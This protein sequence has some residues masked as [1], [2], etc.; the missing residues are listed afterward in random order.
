[1][2]WHIETSGAR[3][4]NRVTID[5]VSDDDPRSEIRHV[6]IRVTPRIGELPTMPFFPEGMVYTD[7]TGVKY[8]ILAARV[9]EVGPD[10]GERSIWIYEYLAAIGAHSLTGPR[11]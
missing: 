2:S 7:R 3:G 4:A 11:L 10:D 1:M 5:P 9:Q 6:C 8:T